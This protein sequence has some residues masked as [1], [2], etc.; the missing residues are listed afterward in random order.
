[1]KNFFDY[2]L[3]GFLSGFGYVRKAKD[4]HVEQNTSIFYYWSSLIKHFSNN[5]N[6][7]RNHDEGS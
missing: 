7:I 6:N 1:M 3:S 5:F 4:I 2:L